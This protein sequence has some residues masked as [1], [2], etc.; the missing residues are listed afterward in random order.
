MIQSWED[1]LTLRTLEETGDEFWLHNF[2]QWAQSP[3]LKKEFDT[4]KYNFAPLTIDLGKLLFEYAALIPIPSDDPEVYKKS[5]SKLL[6]DPRL[7]RIFE[8]RSKKLNN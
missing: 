2:L 8:E 4:L 1:Y 5:V 7:I 6:K 3:Y